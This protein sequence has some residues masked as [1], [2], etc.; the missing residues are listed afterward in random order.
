MEPIA[1]DWACCPECG[2]QLPLSQRFCF[3]GRDLKAPPAALP[4]PGVR[5]W[6]LYFC[7]QLFVLNPLL[8]G[9]QVTTEFRA[10]DAAG[11]LRSLLAPIVGLDSTVRLVLVVLGVVGGALLVRRSGR[12]LQFIRV[13]LVVFAIAHFALASL[14]FFFGLPLDVRNQVVGTLL[15]RA[16]MMVPATTFWLLY[17]KHSKRVKATYSVAKARQ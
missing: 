11:A 8:I 6:L 4:E 15:Y 9:F 13:Y 2:K 5:G 3:C 7:L 14:P 10:L 12:A 16:A 1:A 17:F